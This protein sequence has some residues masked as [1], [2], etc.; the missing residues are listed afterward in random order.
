MPVKIVIAALSLL[1][2]NISSAH[3]DKLK[4]V[5]SFSILGDMIHNVAGD[6]IDL[7]V[8]VGADGDTHAYEPTP[9]D[10]KA[11]GAADLVIVNGLD[12]ENWIGQLI[13]SSGYSKQV[14]TAT[15][16]IQTIH[17]TGT[18]NHDPHAWQ[19]LANGRIY[20]IN[21]RDALI[22]ADSAH[23]AAYRDNAENYLKQINALDSWAKAEIAKIPQSKRTVISTHDAFGYFSQGYGVTFIAPQGLGSES[24]VSAANLAQLIDEIRNKGIEA[25]FLEN[26]SDSRLMKQVENETGAYV[27]GTLYSD[28][29]SPADGPAASY[30][31]MMRHNVTELSNGMVK[32]Q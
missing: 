1:F 23:A 31:A 18:R 6:N 2:V 21:I 4:V 16:G 14:V 19:N 17:F 5:T 9:A 28:A 10:A 25:L 8:L 26:I 27:G 30:L 29:L 32:N 3:A 22:E 11:L 20:V 12:F 15:K 13:V 7:T 24:N